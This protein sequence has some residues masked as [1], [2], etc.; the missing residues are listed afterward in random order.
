MSAAN[1]GRWFGPNDE[2]VRVLLDELAAWTPDQAVIAGECWAAA[3]LGTWGRSVASVLND[4]D[5]PETI[6]AYA[7]ARVASRLVAGRFA[8]TSV[9]WT[10][11]GTVEWVTF[12]ATEAL[13]TTVAVRHL[14][15]EPDARMLMLPL[16]LAR[17][18]P[19]LTVTH[20]PAAVPLLLAL[21]RGGERDV[22]RM[23]TIVVEA[24]SMT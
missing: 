2:Q 3:G 17:I 18:V 15:C 24:L 14:L 23:R 22:E 4:P 9:G 6:G 21:L 12:A 5:P 20:G 8:G 11:S 1:Q 7:A 13:A 19:P 16:D 10:P